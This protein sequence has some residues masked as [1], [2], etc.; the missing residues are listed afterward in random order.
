MFL[1]LDEFKPISRTLAHAAG[2]AVLCEVSRRLRSSARRSDIV[3]RLAG[4]EFVMI[5]ADCADDKAVYSLAARI[6][7]AVNAPFTR[8]GQPLPL[9][10]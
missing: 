10:C 7:A 2:D 3:A 1:D 4:D 6:R 9:R 5:I 8:D